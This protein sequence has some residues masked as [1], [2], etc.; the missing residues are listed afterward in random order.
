MDAT[1]PG[2]KIRE[3][4]LAHGI[5]HFGWSKLTR[6]LSIDLYKAWIDEGQHLD[7][8]YLKDHLAAKE[9]ASLTP[10]GKNHV[11]QSAIIFSVPYWPHSWPSEKTF[12]NQIAL[13]ARGKDYHREIA[14]QTRPLLEQLQTHF[15]EHQFEIYTDSAP[16]LERDLAY[17]SGLGWIGKNTCLIHPKQGSL[18]FLAEIYTSLPLENENPW[19]SDFCGNCNKCIEACPT[20]ALTDNRK[21]IPARCISYWTIEAKSVPPKEIRSGIGDWLFGCDICQ[22]V[23]PWNQKHLKNKLQTLA[24]T[25]SGNDP[26]ARIEE[27]SWI[28]TASR[29]T[30]AK[31]FRE[32]PL[33]RAAGWKLQRNAIIIATNCGYRELLPAIE[34]L[35][36][37]S[38]LAELCEWSIA[39]LTEHKLI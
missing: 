32:T 36:K 8:T 34:A 25:E 3:L 17:R 39:I 11:A 20:Q 15:P 22:T 30:L 33:A 29:K 7:M 28:L 9:N 26:Q 5:N 4:L 1:K 24:G 13:Y 18:F 2:L 37:D 31:E 16:I 10:L 21:L 19:S 38:K 12:A 14:K 23:C 27:L 35:K 6:P